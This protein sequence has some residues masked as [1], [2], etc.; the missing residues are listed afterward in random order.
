MVVKMMGIRAEFERT[1]HTFSLTTSSRFFRKHLD[2]QRSSSQPEIALSP[3]LRLLAKRVAMTFTMV[4]RAVSSIPTLES[5]EKLEKQEEES[6]QICYDSDGNVV[7][8]KDLKV[9]SPWCVVESTTFPG[10]LLNKN[11]LFS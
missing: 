7:A 4:E 9:M 2:V 5:N 10:L 8:T 11:Y 6:I 1:L 3:S